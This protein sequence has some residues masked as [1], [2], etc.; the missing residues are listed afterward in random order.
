MEINSS[1]THETCRPLLED[2]ST[3]PQNI[4]AYAATVPESIGML[5]RQRHY[6]DA[7][8]AVWDGNYTLLPREEAMWPFRTYRSGNAYGANLQPLPESWFERMAEEADWDAYGK[9]NRTAVALVNLDLRNFPTAQPLFRD[10]RSAGEG[11]PFDYVQNSSVFAGEPL[12]ISHLSRDGAWAY[13]LTSY[14]T[15][16]VPRRNV[17][18]VSEEDAKALRALPLVA[19]MNDNMPLYDRQGNYLFRGRVGMLLPCSDTNTTVYMARTVVSERDGTAC[20]VG[21]PISTDAAVPLPLQMNRENLVRVISGVMQSKYGWGGL[22]GERDCSSTLRDIF[23]PFGI[24]LPRNSFRQ[25]QVGRVVSFEGMNNAR[26]LETIRQYAVPF[27]TLLYL[28]GHILLY[29]GTYDGVPV[30]LHNTWGI[31]TEN[32]GDMGRYLVGGVVISSL[33]PGKE[34]NGFQMEN[35]ILSKLISMNVVAEV[36]EAAPDLY[37]A[38]GGD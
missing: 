7:Y 11:F 25:S 36:Y 19:L 10:P 35:T 23:A 5:D 18:Y 9:V 26:K 13:A 31:K 3:F 37:Q 17:A 38:R 34:L 2:L 12:R 20:D 15:G 32:D 24:W 16:W 30:A 4:E 29:L 33:L 21:I 22:Y 27:R 28:K 14:A 6:K 1:C 8:Y